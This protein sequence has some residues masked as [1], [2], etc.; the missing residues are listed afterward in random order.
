[1]SA[2]RSPATARRRNTYRSSARPSRR[3]RASSGRSAL[4][5]LV[6]SGA[7]IALIVIVVARVQHDHA[8]G[9]LPLTNAAV[10]REQAAEKHLD[11][12]L[13]AAVIY[14]ETKF[15][16]RTSAAGALGLMQIEPATAEYIAHL[17]GGTRFTTG[18]LATPK[19]NVAYGSWYL[20]Y[21]LAHYEGDEMLAIA[22]YNAGL[23]NVDAWVAKA[24]AEGGELTVSGIPFP[25]TKAY[26]ERVLRAQR[27]YR[28]AYPHALGI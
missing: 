18:D 14:A 13:I 11:P 17:S 24:R 27:E 2:Q 16:P 23:A 10:I 25:E 21:L 6:A 9:G 19:I 3:A 15:E 20:R 4:R 5:A 8:S 1:M 28:A 26:V 7:L 22:A 12:A